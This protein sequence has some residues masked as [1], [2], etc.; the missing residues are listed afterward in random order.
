M[1]RYINP[2]IFRIEQASKDELKAIVLYLCKDSN[3]RDVV[4]EQ[5]SKVRDL[6][7]KEYK[8]AA[9]LPKREPSVKIY[10]CINCD[11]PFTEET[12]DG[13]VCCYH[14]SIYSQ[15]LMQRRTL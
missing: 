11:Q 4:T 15:L 14:S 5:L 12:N 3:T 10:V 6:E 2:K 8:T 1:D 9:R 7:L 13:L